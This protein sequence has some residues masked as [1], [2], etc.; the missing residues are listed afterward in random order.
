M[1]EMELISYNLTSVEDLPANAKIKVEMGDLIVSKV[2]PYRGAVSIIRHN[3][4]DL[5]VS[6]AFTILRKTSDYP[7]ET[8]AVLFRTQ[9]YKDWLLKW[10]V[11]SSYPV[12]KDEDV[13]NIPIPLFDD[14]IHDIVKATMISSENLKQKSAQLLEQAKQAVEMSIEKDEQTALDWLASQE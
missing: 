8:L 1:L 12:I 13:M 14:D 11:G 10:N 9:I 5:V 2:R 4:Q 7:I 6:G 3:L